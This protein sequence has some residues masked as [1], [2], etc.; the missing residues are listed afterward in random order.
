MPPSSTYPS[1]NS[2]SGNEADTDLHSPPV[3][4]DNGSV[5]PIV[6]QA[7][8]SINTRLRPSHPPPLAFLLRFVP[9]DNSSNNSESA[10]E[11]SSS[12]GDVD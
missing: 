11:T 5:E 8:L 10:T 9:D 2:D 12:D 7:P 3:Q 6:Y 1:R 4:K